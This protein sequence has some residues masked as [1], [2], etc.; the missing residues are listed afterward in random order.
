MN[1]TEALN[2]IASVSWTGCT[3]GLVR[4]SE[5]LEKIGNPQD[6]MPVIHIAGTNGK[7]STAASLSSILT[8]A[9][10]KTGLC[11]SPYI[12][13]FNERMQC[14]GVEITDEELCEI[15]EF[16]KP[17]ADSMQQNPTEFELV[18]AMTFEYFRRKE[19][20][21]VVVEAGL[22]G[23]LDATNIVKKPLCSVIMNI[24][25]DHVAEL[26]D[27]V[28][29]IAF[30]KAG[31][32]KDNCPTILYSQA[33]SVIDVIKSVCDEKNSDLRVTDLSKLTVLPHGI[34]G[35]EFEYKGER[36]CTP[37][38]GE[39][40]AKNAIV[41]IETIEILRKMGYSIPQD[42]VLSGFKKAKWPARFEIVGKDPW[43]IVDGGHNSQCAETV[44]NNIKAYFPNKKAVVLTGIMYD[45]DYDSLIRIIDEVTS[46]YVTITP[47]YYR[48]LSAEK[49]AEYIRQYGKE[50][51]VCGEIPLG[52]ETARK[53][54]GKDGIVVAVGSLYMAGPIRDCFEPA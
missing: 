11:T 54:A 46:E 48:A 51:T 41:A 10:F 4:I 15:T 36:Y 32:I 25:L 52:V 13:R 45:K 35:T 8:E 38:L 33:Q 7:G 40:Q 21:I 31:I 50:V 44:V 28:E 27:T 19:C 26:G 30:E 34:E 23:R 49:Y 42:K 14:D 6:K 1:V 18:C 24:G 12:F 22:G 5:L 43:F 39:H 17:H 37:L 20:D 16:I 3:P 47:D 2:Y 29:K 53:L 9:G